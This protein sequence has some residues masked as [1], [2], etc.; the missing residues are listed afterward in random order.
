MLLILIAVVVAVF[1]PA[2]GWFAD[3]WGV[4]VKVAIALLFFL[5]GARLPTR[6]AVLGLKN[7][8]LHLLILAFTFVLFPLLGFALRPIVAPLVGE[9]L[10][11]GVLFLTLVPSTVQSSVAFTSIARGN[12]AGAIVAA[13]LSNVVGVVATPLLVLLLM[14][15]DGGLHID[16]SVFGDIALQLF[17][18][19]CVGQ[20]TQKW[21]HTVADSPATKWVDRG[22]IGMVVYAAFSAGMVEGIWRSTGVW[23]ILF[24]TGLSVVVVA[25]M[26][27]FTQ[28]VAKRMGMNRGDTIAA[29][30]CG[31]KKS[32]ASGLPMASVI[33][34]SGALGLLILPLM[35]FHQIQLMMCSALASR[36]ARE[37]LDDAA[38]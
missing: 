25:F 34:S 14:T 6:E 21:T 32:L 9:E 20:L 2:S 29:E 3:A 28:F 26:L 18:P 36:Y 38:V 11:A 23:Q 27:W 17:V 10:Y 12:V 30:F 7:W 1:F 22:S 16:T 15:T 31:T 24:I 4:A 5:Y 19:F 35:I 8:K 13:S 33:F 37:E